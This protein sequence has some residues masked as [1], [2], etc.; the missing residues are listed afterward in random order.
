[1]ADPAGLGPYLREHIPLSAALG[2]EVVDASPARVHVHAPLAPNLNHRRTAFG[3]SIS[4]VAILAGWGLLWV[5]LRGI[6]AGHHIVIH[7]NSVSYLAPVEDDFEAVCLPPGAAVWERFLRT[8]ERRGKARLDLHAEVRAG[9]VLAAE[10][11]GR[12]VVLA[13][14]DE[15]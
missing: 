11:R 7:S 6:T 14:E 1:M 12:Y 3:G 9:G 5:R 10:F 4:A 8:L 2:V 13:P 15:R